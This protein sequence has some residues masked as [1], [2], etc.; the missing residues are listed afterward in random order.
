MNDT[1]S[2]FLHKNQI[3]NY[4]VLCSN[5]GNK[6]GVTALHLASLKD[7]LEVLDFLVQKGADIKK[8]MAED[9]C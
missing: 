9:C 2:L 7:C 5:A 8:G 1:R 4:Y 6:Y 3:L